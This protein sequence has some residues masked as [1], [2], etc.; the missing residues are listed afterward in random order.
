MLKEWERGDRETNYK[1]AASLLGL[2]LQLVLGIEQR[3]RDDL[4]GSRIKKFIEQNDITK[5]EKMKKKKCY[6]KYIYIYNY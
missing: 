6:T 4:T 5:N 1:V 3:K 2:L